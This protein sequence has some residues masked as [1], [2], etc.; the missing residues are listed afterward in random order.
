LPYLRSPK[1]IDWSSYYQ[2]KIDSYQLECFHLTIDYK[3]A[4]THAGATSF[5][6]HFLPFFF[7][8]LL[9]SN[10]CRYRKQFELHAFIEPPGKAY[11]HHCILLM[12]P[13]L[14]K[15]FQCKCLSLMD[16]IYSKSQLAGM[17]D[18]QRSFGDN[19]YK[20]L[21]WL[22][23]EVVLKFKT[24]EVRSVSIQPLEDRFSILKASTYAGKRYELF[25]KVYPDDCYQVFPGF[26]K[27]A[28]KR[29]LTWN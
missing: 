19:T 6:N 20:L 15:R 25:S 24:S 13:A 3:T 18:F 22:A 10:W 28:T 29:R 2:D 5:L 4:S 11:H 21:K 7:S 17:S 16:P 8:K 14:A 27:K 1:L 12:T 23:G 26:Y 9:T